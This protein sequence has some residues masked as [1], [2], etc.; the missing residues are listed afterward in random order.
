MFI[1]IKKDMSYQTLYIGVF[2]FLPFIKHLCFRRG[3]FAVILRKLHLTNREFL[4]IVCHYI[5]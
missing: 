3:S 5:F 2:F 4:W 1:H